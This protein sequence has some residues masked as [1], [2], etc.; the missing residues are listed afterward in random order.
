MRS[1]RFIV[2]I[3]FICAY[4]SVAAAQ[5]VAPSVQIV[6]AIDESKLVSLKGNT[7]PFANAKND[8]GRVSPNLRMTDLI[9]V[10]SRS[11]QQQAAFDK[12]VA[13]QYDPHSPNFHQW[14]K[15]DEVGLD[16]GPSQAD[17]ATISSWLAGHGFS[18]DEVT[19]DRMSIR[20]SGTAARANTP[21]GRSGTADSGPSS[22]PASRESSTRT[23][24]QMDSP[25]S[26]SRRR[27]SRALSTPKF[28]TWK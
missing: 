16:F 12:F 20:F 3:A 27:R 4:L 1:A 21:L 9:L 22:R 5:A 19:R 17:I 28:T 6:R 10:L 7:H 25:R 26:S 18:I 24:T 13:S 14:L 23:P 11:P 2:L 15:P 8:R